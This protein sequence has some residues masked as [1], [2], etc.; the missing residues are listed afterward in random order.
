VE[1]WRAMTQSPLFL[2][3]REDFTCLHCGTPVRGNGYTNHCPRCLWSRHVD[4]NPGDRAA[5][6]GAAMEPIGALSEGGEIIVVHQCL[7]CGHSRRN[8]SALD[9]DRDVLLELFGRPVPDP[10]VSNRLTR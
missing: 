9:D 6:C 1:C 2:R 10:P 3:R 5:E 4:V 8:R 7:A